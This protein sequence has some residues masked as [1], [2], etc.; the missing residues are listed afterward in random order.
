V[1]H[2]ALIAAGADGAAGR[3]RMGRDPVTGLQCGFERNELEPYFWPIVPL[4]GTLQRPEALMRWNHPSRDQQDLWTSP[5]IRASLFQNLIE[6]NFG[7]INS[8]FRALG[9]DFPVISW[10]AQPAS[11]L[12]AITVTRVWQWTGF[13]TI[14]CIAEISVIP[15]QIYEAAEI[16]GCGFGGT[17]LLWQFPG[18]NHQ[19]FQMFALQAV[20]R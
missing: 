4:N 14:V 20:V 11:A 17:L 15:R 1:T 19:L 6:T 5:K 2:V 18:E 10:L 12:E 9:A 8:A 7:L 16:K 3:D 13:F